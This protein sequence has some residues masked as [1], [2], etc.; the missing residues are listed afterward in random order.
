[1]KNTVKEW[2]EHKKH[3]QYFEERAKIYNEKF[4]S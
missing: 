3:L 1:M 4:L 2:Q